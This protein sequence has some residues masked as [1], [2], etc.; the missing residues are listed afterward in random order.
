MSQ[1]G[2]IVQRPLT[3]VLELVD[4]IL[5]KGLVVDVYLKV[6]VV[7]I[8]LL[9]VQ[10]RVVVAGIETY[11]KYASE[12]QKLGLIAKPYATAA[13]APARREPLEAK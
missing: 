12:M 8:E 2:D 1:V 9:E 5:D 4:R 3:S 10:A 13:P 11:L 6:S 7:G